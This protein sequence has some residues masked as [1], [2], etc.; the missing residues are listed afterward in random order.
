MK[1]IYFF[2]IPV[3]RLPE[4]KYYNDRERHIVKTICGAEISRNEMTET[5]LYFLEKHGSSLAERYGGAWEFNEI[6]GYIKLHVLGHQVRGEY[7]TTIPNRKVRTRKKQYIMATHKLAPEVSLN[8]DSDNSGIYELILEYV[9]RCRL[10]LPLRYI[11]DSH[12]K[13]VGPYLDWLKLIGSTQR[14]DGSKTS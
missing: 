13:T 11:D 5:Q 8:R 2:D 1:L 10:E 14:D 12:I 7:F 3:Y 4:D 6:V 9:E